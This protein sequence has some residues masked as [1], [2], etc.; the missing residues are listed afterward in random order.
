MLPSSHSDIDVHGCARAWFAREH[1]V[2]VRPV[3][4]Q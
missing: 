4:K 2:I 1:W 3:I